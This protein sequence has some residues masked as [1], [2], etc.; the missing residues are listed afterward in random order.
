MDCP[1]E[2]PESIRDEVEYI[3]PMTTP[4]CTLYFFNDVL[5]MST[6][7]VD[8]SDGQTVE[9]RMAAKRAQFGVKI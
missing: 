9:A 6:F 4:K 7:T 3:G 1:I 2:I 5:T 8:V